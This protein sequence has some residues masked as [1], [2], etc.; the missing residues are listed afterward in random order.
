MY[1][2]MEL[3]FYG[4]KMCVLVGLYSSCVFKYDFIVYVVHITGCSKS[5]CAPDDYGTKTRKIF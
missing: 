5:L 4:V 3:T 1:T 2:I